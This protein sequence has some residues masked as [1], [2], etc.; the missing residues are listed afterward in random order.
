MVNKKSEGEK[1][2]PISLVE[3]IVAKHRAGANGTLYLQFEKSISDFRTSVQNP[4]N[5]NQE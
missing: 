4:E 3:L 2:N 5:R 1:E